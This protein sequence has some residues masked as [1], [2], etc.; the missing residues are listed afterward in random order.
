MTETFS[1][2]LHTE[3]YP[4]GS[5][6]SGSPEG[7]VQSSIHFG[8]SNNLMNSLPAGLVIYITGTMNL[9]KFGTS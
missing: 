6:S 8:E 1:R 9:I 4:Y 3:S 2:F 7:P 5:A